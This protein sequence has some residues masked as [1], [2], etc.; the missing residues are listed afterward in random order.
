M[1]HR[2]LRRRDI[3][4]QSESF[5]FKKT[6]AELISQRPT[7][8][9]QCAE[10]KC[11]CLDHPLHIGDR[12][13]ELLLQRGKRNVH[14]RAIDES[15]RRSEDRGDQR[16]LFV[17]QVFWPQRIVERGKMNYCSWDPRA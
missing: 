10:K 16:P 8:Q 15:H 4:R 2:T 13:A 11:V 7:N 5:F 3:R 14:D 9:D 6:V 1:M 12:C 17:F